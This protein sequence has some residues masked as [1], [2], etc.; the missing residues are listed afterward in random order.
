[1]KK[2]KRKIFF[3]EMYGLF[4]CIFLFCA[5]AKSQSVSKLIADCTITYAVSFEGSEGNLNTKILYIK[6]KKTR[7]DIR[8]SSFQQSTIFDNKTGDAVVLKNI[9]LDKYISY[10]NAQQWKEKNKKWDDV[11]ISFS[12]ETKKV[13]T[14]TCR[15]AILVTK[16]NNQFVVYYTLDFG[17]SATENPYQFKNILGLILEYESQTGEGKLITFKATDVNLNPVPA[18][19]FEI[20]TTGYRVL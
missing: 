2:T 20:P 6:G 15:K 13:L 8:Y 16:D 9:G 7:T 4:L 1:M 5:Q 17:A 3:L 18:S 14:Y 11:K 19:R 12:N 10:F